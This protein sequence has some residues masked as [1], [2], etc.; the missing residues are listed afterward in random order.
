[1]GIDRDWIILT[2]LFYAVLDLM[3]S[4]TF[5]SILVTYVGN[6]LVLSIRAYFAEI[7]IGAK[8]LVDEKFLVK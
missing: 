1:M 5:V 6:R 2:S 8:T 3:F 4:N 7:N